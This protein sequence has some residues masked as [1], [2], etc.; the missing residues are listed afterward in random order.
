M[1]KVTAIVIGAGPGGYVAAIRLGQLGVD[2]LLVEKETLG[3]VCLNV[4]CIPSKALIH[5][6]HV[7]EQFESA[8]EMGI[9]S[10]DLNIDAAKMQSWKRSVVNRLTGGVAALC[11]QNGVAISMGTAKFTSDRSVVI[12]DD[13]GGIEDVQFDYAVIATGSRPIEIP[14]FPFDEER[15]LSST[16]ALALETIPNHLVVIGGGYIG[17]E[18]G[19]MWRKLGAAVTV[20]EMADSVLPGFDTEAVRLIKANLRKSSITVHTGARALGFNASDDLVEVQIEKAGEQ[21]TIECDRVLVTVGRKPTVEGLAIEAAGINVDERGFIPVDDQCR[22]RQPHIFAIG[23]VS[24]EPLLAHRASRQGEVAAEVIAGKRAGCDWRTVPAVVFTAPEIAACGLMEEDARAQGIEVKIGKFPFAANGKALSM[25]AAQGFVKIIIDARDNQ[26]LGGLI[27]GPEASTMISELAL[28]VE[29]GAM[30][31]D[32]ALTI[33]PHPTLGE[34][35]MEAA[36]HALGHAIHTVN[37]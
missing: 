36:A 6:G 2:T 24:G 22:T 32:L 17:L 37:K 16:G 18:L 1:R 26:V 21:I 29:M 14:T 5:A 28:A 3:G 7:V 10:K 31:E 20:V 25:N 15:I 13:R 33:H 30:A 19:Q 8:R 27:I 23:D 4:G 9:T 12:S 11:K 35:V 34:T